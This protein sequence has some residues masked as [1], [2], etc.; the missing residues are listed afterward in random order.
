MFTFDK[1]IRNGHRASGFFAFFA[2]DTSVTICVKVLTGRLPT[3]AQLHM[4]WPDTVPLPLC[5]LC[6]ALDAQDH[7]FHCPP[8]KGLLWSCCVDVHEQVQ[9]LLSRRQLDGHA[10]VA[11]VLVD[12]LLDRGKIQ[13]T[14]ACVVDIQ[15]RHQFSELA[16][17]LVQIVAIVSTTIR[18]VL[19]AQR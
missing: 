18:V 4:Y 14:A 16:A 3:H 2:D 6:H 8:L 12:A 17:L 5:V 13:A 10:N 11:R 19:W 7:W 9:G 1:V 15:V